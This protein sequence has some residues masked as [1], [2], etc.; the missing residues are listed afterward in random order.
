M[1]A[2]L[3]L[4]RPTHWVKNL[5]V[6]APLIFS[7][8]LTNLTLLPRVLAAFALFSLTASALYIL[9][10]ILDRH[11]D[12]QHP[13]KCLRPIPSGRVRVP[14]AIALAAGLLLFSLTTALWVKHWL[15]LFLVAYLLLQMLYSFWFKHHALLDVLCIAIGFVLRA[16]AGAEVADLTVSPW[17]IICTFTLCLFLGFSKRRMEL[18]MLTAAPEI[19][20]LGITRKSLLQYTPDLLNQLTSVSA[21]IAIMAFLLYTLDSSPRYPSPFDRHLL[22]YTVPLVVYGVFRFGML[23]ERGQYDGPT[24]LLLHD[25]PFQLTVLIWTVLAI[26]IIYGFSQPGKTY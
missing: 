19:S 5:F 12:A 14:T 22:L 11:R 25:R 16:M 1:L 8:Q 10:D 13:R 20:N 17:L 26:G 18:G 21:G 9:N 4:L 6:L 24:E 7:L 3:Q 23:A 15:A 2:Y